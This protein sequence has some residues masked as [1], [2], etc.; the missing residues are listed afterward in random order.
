M[1][2]DDFRFLWQFNGDLSRAEYLMEGKG[3]YTTLRTALPDL[4]WNAYDFRV[5]AVYGV[6]F[7]FVLFLLEEERRG[8]C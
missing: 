1:L 8:R 7:C 2:A 3:P 6:R 5:R 4:F